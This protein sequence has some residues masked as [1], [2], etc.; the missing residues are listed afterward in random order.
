MA[1]AGKINFRFR[2]ER[3]EWVLTDDGWKQAPTH[4]TLADSLGK[5]AATIEATSMTAAE[6]NKALVKITVQPQVMD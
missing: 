4:G 3:V 2:E 6:L 1:T 5:F